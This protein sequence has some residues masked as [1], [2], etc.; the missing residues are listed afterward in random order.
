MEVRVTASMLYD[1]VSCEHRPWMDLHADPRLR[2]PVNPFVEMLWRRGRMHED[3]V[4]G[5]GAFE[6]PNLRETPVADRARRTVECMQAGIPLIYGGRLEVDDLVGEPDLLRL[7]AGGYVPGDIKSGAG[8]EGPSDDRR[9]KK[10]YA[11]Q[12]ALYVDAM[13]RLGFGAAHR[14]AFVW[15]VN[16][17][18]VEYDLDQPKGPRT[19]STFWDDYAEC[20]AHAR[21]AITGFGDSAPAYSAACKLC[22]WRT[23]CLATLEQRDDLTLIPGLG[24]SKREPLLPHVANV[25]ALAEATADRFLDGDGKSIVKGLGADTL[26]KLQARALLRSSLG[27]PYLT[28]PLDLP[29]NPVELFF[30]IETDPLRNHCYLHGFVER[31]AGDPASETYTAFFS[32]APTE[33]AERAAFAAAW[34]FVQSRR[35]CTIYIYSK[36]ERTWRRQLQ[37]LGTRLLL[38]ALRSIQTAAT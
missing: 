6:A 33:E 5:S 4:V 17:D 9:P 37:H 3:A 18:E 15:D 14:R 23:A 35:P 22:V 11:M 30:D 21:A 38:D 1:L 36:Y 24:R 31:R 7:E 20:L 19:P 16:G 32:E 29:S 13:G 34:A 10:Q 27:Q 8:E 26:R 28:R 2:D 12:L 25:T